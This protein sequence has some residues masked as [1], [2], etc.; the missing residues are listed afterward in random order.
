[1]GHYDAI[2]V[3]V[4]RHN[5]VSPADLAEDHSVP[6]DVLKKLIPYQRGAGA[7]DSA[8]G[9]TSAFSSSSSPSFS[10]ADEANLEDFETP[11]SCGVSEVSGAAAVERR[12]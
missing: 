6:D 3:E 4:L 11:A 8:N 12:R 2:K 7:S 9:R 1:M 5:V 10:A